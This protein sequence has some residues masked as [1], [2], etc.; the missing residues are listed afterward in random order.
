MSTEGMKCKEKWRTFFL[1]A[2]KNSSCY[3]DPPS[4][5]MMNGRKQT[6][7]TYQFPSNYH[8]QGGPSSLL[9]LEDS[10]VMIQQKVEMEMPQELREHRQGSEL[11]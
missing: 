5:I 2:K 8:D 1:R 4:V 10:K 9:F 6:P 3:L 11:T 7:D